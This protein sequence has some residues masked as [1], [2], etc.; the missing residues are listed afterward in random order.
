MNKFLSAAI[1]LS[2]LALSTIPAAK[3]DTPTYFGTAQAMVNDGAQKCLDFYAGPPSSDPDA[4]AL[5]LW[6]CMGYYQPN[7]QW[8]W[9]G[10]GKDGEGD[11]DTFAFQN[12]ATN[13]C[14]AVENNSMADG[15]RLVQATCDYTNPGQLWIRAT[16]I[17]PSKP[18]TY[19]TK[20]INVNS[21]KCMDA[22]N[23]DNGVKLQQWTCQFTRYW[24]QQEF[25]VN[26]FVN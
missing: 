21:G 22:W 11:W 10:V 23:K 17:G 9:I 8:R 2:V 4:Y 18:A 3:A 19:R 16:K 15:A 13:T 20:W 26:Y 14:I 24:W 6:D 5:Q 1:A 7:K 12:V 25:F